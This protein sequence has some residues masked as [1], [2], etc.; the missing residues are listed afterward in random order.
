MARLLK[1]AIFIG[2]STVLSISTSAQKLGF[3]EVLEKS[4]NR[5]TTFCVPNNDQNVSL[6]ENH[7][8]TIKYSTQEWCFISATPHWIDEAS[9]SGD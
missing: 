4:P 3:K 6:I 1:H 9:K 2:I 7:G 5:L 8:L